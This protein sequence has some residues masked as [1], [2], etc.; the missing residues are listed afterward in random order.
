MHLKG[1]MRP[2]KYRY[3]LWQFIAAMDTGK[4]DSLTLEEVQRHADARTIP[5]FLVDRFGSD[6]DLSM[7][8]PQDWSAISDAWANLSNAV[9]ARRKFGVENRGICLLMAYTQECLQSGERNS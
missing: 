1:N 8:E 2:H 7:I 4:Y 9:D 6:L 5:A 3:L